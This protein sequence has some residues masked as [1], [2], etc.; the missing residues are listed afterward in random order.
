[1]ILTGCTRR[2]LLLYSPG[3]ASVFE[4]EDIFAARTTTKA[5]DRGPDC[6]VLGA[7]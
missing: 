7:E 2:V 6:R 1:M 3:V 4:Q 5:T